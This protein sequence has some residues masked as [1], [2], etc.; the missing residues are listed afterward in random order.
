MSF[1]LS[2]ALASARSSGGL[3]LAASTPL[4]EFAPRE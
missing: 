1:L 3:Q 2:V 4:V